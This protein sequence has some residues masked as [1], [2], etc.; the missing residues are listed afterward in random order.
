M[1]PSS[2]DLRTV[3]GTSADG[4][5]LGWAHWA[6]DRALA[7][8]LALALRL[9]LR[10]RVPFAGWVAQHLVAPLAG[11][12]RRVRA[13]L[14]HVCP[15]LPESEVRR[16]CGRVSNNIGRAMIELFSGAEFARFAATQPLT[17]PGVAALEAA[18]AHKRPVVLV[19]GHLGNYDV[20][21][22]A[23]LAHGYRVGGLY[24]PMSNP[25]A[26][27]R[28][29]AAIES[30]GKPLFPRGRGG[31][32]GMVRFLRQGGMLGVVAD[33][34]MDHGEPLDF[35]GKPALTALSAAELA[36]KYGALLV[37]VYGIRQADG[38]HFAIRIE[39]PVP[40]SDARTMT[41]ALNDSLAAQVRE[42]CDQ[43]F[44]VHRR[45]GSV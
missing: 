34:H 15:D 10:R 29:I 25:A 14:A 35:L 45:W 9:P 26:N 11:A 31:M 39:A 5:P 41:Q 13:N 42:H 18:H 20:A 37:P 3:S 6:E 36:L 30:I 7:V 27:R 33:Q 19:T 2:P 24:M 38:L 22:A 12:N 32:A 44:W 4:A 21:R 16:L 17:G 40:P 1:P 43:W 28:Y 23:L 8:L